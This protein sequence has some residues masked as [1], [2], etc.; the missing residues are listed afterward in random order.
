MNLSNTT[1]DGNQTGSYQSYIAS[2]TWRNP[3]LQNLSKFLANDSQSRRNCRIACLEFSSESRVPSS[4]SLDL[5]SLANLLHHQTKGNNNLR[6]RILIIE[7]LSKDIIQTLGSIL[8]IDPFFFASHI[9]A[10]RSEIETTRPYMATLPSTA[11]SQNFLTLHYHRTL[12]FERGPK[13]PLLRDMNVPRKVKALP[14]IK[15]VNVGLARHCCSIMRT[16]G[17]DG[18]W[19]GTRHCA[20]TGNE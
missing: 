17:K 20:M 16:M 4:R 7:D 1:W 8:N 3:S 11:K 12:K 14:S 19:L 15:N 10:P 18:L 9:D 2:R 5:E 13:G 6:G